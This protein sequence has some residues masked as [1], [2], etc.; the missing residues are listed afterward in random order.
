MRY[1]RA[2]QMCTR[3]ID[4][5][6]HLVKIYF[7]ECTYNDKHIQSKYNMHYKRII[8]LTIDTVMTDI[9][10]ATANV[11]LEISPSMSGC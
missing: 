1:A 11:P 2:I 7:H 10:L 9:S 5:L 6:Y 4:D 8:K 3:W